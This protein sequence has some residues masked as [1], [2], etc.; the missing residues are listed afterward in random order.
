[1][2]VWPTHHRSHPPPSRVVPLRG[3]HHRPAVARFRVVRPHSAHG[4]ARTTNDSVYAVPAFLCGY[5]VHNQPGALYDGRMAK[6]CG[7]FS[8][9]RTTI[10]Q[11]L[12][13]AEREGRSG[14][15]RKLLDHLQRA[16]GHLFVCFVSLSYWT[17]A[18]FHS[19]GCSSE[20]DDTSLPLGRTGNI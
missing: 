5:V 8:H 6:S 11:I 16:G 14:K 9:Q 1:M 18:A 7:E 2:T 19:L 15:L 4:Q 20:C 12:F 17:S 3:Q 13:H 10:G